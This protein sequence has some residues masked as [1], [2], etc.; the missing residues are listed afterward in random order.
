MNH[1]KELKDNPSSLLYSSL[2]PIDVDCSDDHDPIMRKCLEEG[3][4]K[5][6]TIWMFADGEV[7]IWLKQIKYITY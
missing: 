7:W 6:P 1:A 2:N 5:T 3:V 4:K